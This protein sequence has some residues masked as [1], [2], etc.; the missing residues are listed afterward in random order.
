MGKGKTKEHLI[1]SVAI[2]N[3]A[4]IAHDLPIRLEGLLI[5]QSAWRPVGREKVLYA[6]LS[7]ISVG[8]GYRSIETLSKTSS[9]GVVSER[10]SYL[11]V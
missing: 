4:V 7:N 2:L 8:V 6:L 9:E 10:V 1:D 3:T 11:S 5:L